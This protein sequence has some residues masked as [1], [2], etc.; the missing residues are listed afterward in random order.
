MN[1]NVVQPTQFYLPV[2]LLVWSHSYEPLYFSS[3]V[4]KCYKSL[5][6]FLFPDLMTKFSKKKRKR[7]N[8]TKNGK[9]CKEYYNSEL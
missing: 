6:W 5:P 2:G 7:N 8:C 3:L 4:L 1:H 9:K